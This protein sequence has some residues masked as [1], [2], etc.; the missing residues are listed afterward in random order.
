MHS[1][2]KATNNV[3][4]HSTHAVHF[5]AGPIDCAGPAVIHRGLDYADGTKP[6]VQAA[7]CILLSVSLYSRRS[8]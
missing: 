3:F 7:V 5:K 6:L 4:T 8:T 1:R 2:M